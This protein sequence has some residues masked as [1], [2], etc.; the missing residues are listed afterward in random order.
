MSRIGKKP[1]GIPEGVT[2]KIDGRQVEVAGSRGS[3]TLILRPEVRVKEAD[4][5]LHLTKVSSNRRAAALW[6]LYRALVANMVEGVSQ[7][8]TEHLLMSGV[9]YRARVEGDKLILSVGFSHPVEYPLPDGVEISVTDNTKITVAGIDKQQV[10]QVAAEIRKV[11]PPEPYKGR[12]IRY[13]DEVVRLKPG[14][15]GKVG[16]AAG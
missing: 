15:A 16:A 5:Q 10:G 8:F 1:I 2:V 13:Q 4:G 6:G 11:R 12:G 9:G 14:K 7:G 3:L